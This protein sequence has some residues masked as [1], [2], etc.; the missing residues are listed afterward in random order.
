MPEA[1]FYVPDHQF[2]TLRTFK[3]MF[4]RNWG[5]LLL[6]FMTQKVRNESGISK[7]ELAE[8]I[9]NKFFGDII[10]EREFINMMGAEDAQ[11]AIRHRVRD[12]CAAD[13]ELFD[14]IIDLLREKLPRLAELGGYK[15]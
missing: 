12:A 11:S 2:D 6:E 9:F 10:N 7:K 13:K 8:K 14:D 3:K 1:R 15:K 5:Q 4:G